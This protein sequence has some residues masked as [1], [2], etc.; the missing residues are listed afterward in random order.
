M[1]NS[2]TDGADKVD[3]W[4]NTDEFSKNMLSFIRESTRL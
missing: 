1:K 2:I 4:Q 3:N